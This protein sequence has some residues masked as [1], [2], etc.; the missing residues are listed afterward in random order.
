LFGEQLP[1][2]PDTETLTDHWREL[3][4][5]RPLPMGGCGAFEWQE[6]AAYIQLTQSDLQPIEAQTLVDMSRAYVSALADENPLSKSPMERN[7]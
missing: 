1:D 6:V 3:G 4:L 7:L 2:L 5:A